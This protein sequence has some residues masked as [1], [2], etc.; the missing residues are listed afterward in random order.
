[1]KAYVGIT[2]YDWYTQLASHSYDEINFWRPGGGS[3]FRVLMPGELFLFKLHSPR[4]YIV[5]GGFFVS[6]SLL[7]TFLA[8]EAFDKKNG[9]ASLEELE[10]KIAKYKKDDNLNPN[11]GCIILRDPFFFPEEEWIP[12]P[13]DWQPSIVQG[14]TYTHDN[15]IGRH[16]IESVLERIPF[17]ANGVKEERFGYG[18]ARYRLGQGAFRV[19]VTDAYKRRCAIS[20]EKTLPVLEAAH[21]RPYSHGGVHKIDN[22][23]LLR[24]DIH[25]LLDKGYLTVTPSYN[26]EVS[27]RLDADYGNGRIYYHYHGL[28]LPNLPS[29][30]EER[31]SKESLIW[32][33]ENI[34]R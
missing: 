5:G 15:P 12:A 31:P 1:M 2:D 28:L 21:I 10:R 3:S 27:P 26:I 11:I 24:K 4:N 17:Y 19:L 18:E 14:K 30:E 25:V 34:F 33:N 9:T 8:W 16:L 13:T 7:P 32:H 22:G 23:I 29:R 20:G 6:F